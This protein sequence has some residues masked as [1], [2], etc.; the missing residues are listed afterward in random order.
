MS[1]VL[2]QGS[3]ATLPAHVHC[4]SSAVF[5]DDLTGLWHETQNLTTRDGLVTSQ[6]SLAANFS[7][8]ARV[9]G[10]TC[11]HDFLQSMILRPV[12]D[13]VCLVELA[14]LQVRSFVPHRYTDA[15]ASGFVLFQSHTP[16]VIVNCPL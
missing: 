3:Y 10:T 7:Y 14:P 12:G 11:I 15:D 5:F 2:E 8:A 13:G 4:L 9:G 16:H 6:V 1:S